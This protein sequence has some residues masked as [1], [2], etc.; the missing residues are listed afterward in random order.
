[1]NKKALLMISR[2]VFAI[3]AVFAIAFFILIFIYPEEALLRI[4]KHY[5][6]QWTAVLAILCNFV[7]VII[8]HIAMKQIKYD[9]NE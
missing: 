2:V 9:R 4:N 1:M 7:S 8:K 3:G 6:Y 5:L